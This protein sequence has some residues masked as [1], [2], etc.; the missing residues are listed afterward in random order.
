MALLIKL[1]MAAKRP[2]R[3]LRKATWKRAV[4]SDPAT[5]QDKGPQPAM[6][7][8]SKW[9]GPGRP[10]HAG[11]AAP[12]VHH[13]GVQNFVTLNGLSSSRWPLPLATLSGRSLLL[14]AMRLNPHVPLS[15]GAAAWQPEVAEVGV[16]LGAPPLVLAP[17]LVIGPAQ[18]NAALHGAGNCSGTAGGAAVS[19]PTS[20]A[21]GGSR[22]G[23]GSG[24]LLLVAGWGWSYPGWP[25]FVAHEIQSLLERGRRAKMR[26]LAHQLH[27]LG[28]G[29]HVAGPIPLQLFVVRKAAIHGPLERV[30][31][32]V[33]RSRQVHELLAIPGI[34]VPHKGPSVRQ[35]TQCEEVLHHVVDWGFWLG[36]G[37]KKVGG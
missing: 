14:F 8:N 13:G 36:K 33:L 22:S 27:H 7:S 3:Q 23:P 37:A 1:A 16:L 21:A 11:S 4:A 34:E 31:C 2:A 9:V 20:L 18:N 35:H 19:I 6:D 10:L 30:V 5:K 12:Y 17:P 26:R 28:P 29:G 32:V 24:S 15:A 25:P